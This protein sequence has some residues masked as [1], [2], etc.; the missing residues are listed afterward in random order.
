MATKE[1]R[2][3]RNAYRAAYT[4][5]MQCVHEMADASQ[6]NERPQDSVLA[7]E[8]EAFSALASTRGALLNALLACERSVNGNSN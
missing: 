1:M 5:Y 8:D 3:L 2:E 4:R 6:R 7:A